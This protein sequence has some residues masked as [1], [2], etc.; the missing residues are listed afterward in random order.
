MSLRYAILDD[1][2][3]VALTLTDWAFTGASVD[4]FSLT[5][6]YEDEAA[7]AAQLVDCA[8]MVVMRGR[9]PLTASLMDRLPALRLVVTSG[10][11]NAAIDLDA[12]RARDITVCGTASDSAH[13]MELTWAVILGLARHIVPENQA[14]RQNG[15]W[16]HSLG[17]TLKGKRLGLLGLGK[18]GGAMARV[19]QAFGMEVVAWSRHLD[20]ESAAAAGV[21]LAASKEA[22]LAASDI[23]SIHLVLSERTRGLIGAAELAQMKPGAL[24]INTSRAAIVERD[25]LITALEQGR[26]AGAGLDVFEVEPLPVQDRLR[27]LPNVLATP[28]L[29]YVSDSNYRLYFREAVEDIQ[30]WLNGAPVRQLT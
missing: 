28:H 7:L 15:P 20:A 8:I 9:T 29:G 5:T 25:A 3:H 2:Q 27:Q 6:H 11:R 21:T 13:V 26:I 17:L 16:Q 24:L 18:I 23:V 1:Y 4:V 30:A 19:A 10:M 14:L 12:A 22:L